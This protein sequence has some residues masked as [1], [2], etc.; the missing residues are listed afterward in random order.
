MNII[1][2]RR[3]KTTDYYWIFTYRRA[4]QYSKS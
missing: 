4:K 1:Y 2:I 3:E